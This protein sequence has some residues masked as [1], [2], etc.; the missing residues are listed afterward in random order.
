MVEPV[1]LVP[2][3]GDASL[4]DGEF[5]L[6]GV[7]LDPGAG[8]LVALCLRSGLFGQRR[9]WA[10]A[11]TLR[12]ADGERVWLS[13]TSGQLRSAQPG[14]VVLHAGLPVR[15]P[16]ER[17]GTLGWVGVAPDGRVAEY[18]LRPSDPLSLSRRLPPERVEQL[19]DR[20]LRVRVERLE[21]LPVL[22]TD[23]ELEAELSRRFWGPGAPL[24]PE[25]LAR[26]ELAVRGGVAVLS[27]LLP[28]EAQR[29]LVCAVAAET[30]GVRGVLDRLETAERLAEASEAQPAALPAVPLAA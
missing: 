18:G 7:A 8:R 9:V 5:G 27:G 20:G 26:L 17:L 22:R 3:R 6:D 15:S 21:D 28:R 19:S 24:P 23:P 14:G 12:Y 1:W 11:D 16:A 30:P 13:L 4:A 29:L 2:L 25:V 10:G